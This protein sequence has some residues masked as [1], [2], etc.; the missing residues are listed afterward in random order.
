V[1]L[2]VRVLPQEHPVLV[3][4][5][6]PAPCRWSGLNYKDERD[7][8][9]KWLADYGDPYLLSASTADGRVGIDFGVYGVPETFVIDRQ[10]V[11]RT[12]TSAR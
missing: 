7:A 4:L 9:L 11:I 12:S 1:G 5:A 2:V 10:G 3:E 6:R 8:G